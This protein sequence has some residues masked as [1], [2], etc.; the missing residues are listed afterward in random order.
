MKIINRFTIFETITFVGLI[1][2]S[3]CNKDVEPEREFLLRYELLKQ[4]SVSGIQS[5]VSNASALYPALDSIP[6]EFNYNVSVYKVE[7]PITFRENRL[8]V[9]GVVCVPETSEEL[10]LISFQNGTNTLHSAAPSRD[11]FNGLYTLIESVASYGFIV[12]IA[13]YLGFGSSEQLLHPYYHRNSNDQAIKNLIMAAEELTHEKEIKAKFN[14][15]VFLMGY[16]QGGWATLSACRVI[17]QTSSIALK[18]VSCGAGAYRLISFSEQVLS[19]ETYPTPYYFPYFI[20]SHRRNG[21]VN[22]PLTLFFKEPYAS[23]IPGLFNGKLSGDEINRQLTDTVSL[24]VTENL[25][26]NFL[27]SGE[28]ESFR[29]ELVMNSIEGWNSNSMIRFY[30]GNTDGNVFYQQSVLMYNEMIQQGSFPQNV[31]LHIFDGL[32]HET[33]LIPWGIT[34]IRWFRSLLEK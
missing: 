12:V 1:I 11:I 10:P 32:N 6:D 21:L 20:E 31:S 8:I 34:S 22:D 25:R 3:G 19:L 13:D 16:S 24:L 9:S 17:E 23:R 27:F 33:A 29:H 2:F 14:G 26:T 4:M 5:F 28:F 15:K 18:A 7:Y 30:H